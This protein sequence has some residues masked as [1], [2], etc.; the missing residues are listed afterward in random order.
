MGLVIARPCLKNGT[1]AAIGASEYDNDGSNGY[2]QVFRFA[3]NEWTQLGSTIFGDTATLYSPNALS[4]DGSI[5]AV[6]ACLPEAFEC[7]AWWTAIGSRW[8]TI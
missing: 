8:E 3:N 6:G 2:V 5:L 7:F 1:I 4:D